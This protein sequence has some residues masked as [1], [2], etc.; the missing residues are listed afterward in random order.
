MQKLDAT[1]LKLLDLLQENAKFTNKELS[2]KLNLS[3]TA[4]FERIKKLERE[5]IIIRYTSI[6]D[7]NKVNYGF[8]VFCHI[9]LIQHTQEYIKQF[10]QEVQQLKEVIECFHVSGDYDYLLKVCVEDMENYR[11]FMVTKLTAL[12][13]IGSTQ[14]SFMIGEGKNTTAYPIS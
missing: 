5:K 7:R 13:H 10:E 2:L 14:S 9:K 11:K 3:V 1:D 4:I 6:L 8:M 12:H